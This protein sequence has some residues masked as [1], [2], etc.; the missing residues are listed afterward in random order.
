MRQLYS[1]ISSSTWPAAA[2]H[3]E[4]LHVQGCHPYFILNIVPGPVPEIVVPTSDPS[5]RQDH[6]CRLCTVRT[7]K[8]K[9]IR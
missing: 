9:D 4:Y 5:G 8:S 7:T 6:A 2:L 1:A 3:K